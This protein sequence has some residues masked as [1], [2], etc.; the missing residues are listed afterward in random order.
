MLKHDVLWLFKRLKYVEQELARKRGKNIDSKNQVDNDL[1]RAED[2][3]YKIPEHLKV[4]GLIL[5]CPSS[6]S[7]RIYIQLL[8]SV[9]G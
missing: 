6:S 9:F 3:L 4:S 5:C 1:M 7:L 2:E 8:L